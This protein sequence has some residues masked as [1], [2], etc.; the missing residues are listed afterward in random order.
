MIVVVRMRVFFCPRPRDMLCLCVA[1]RA[2]ACCSTSSCSAFAQSWNSS[3]TLASSWR[4][5]WCEDKALKSARIADT[6][7]SRPR[8]CTFFLIQAAGEQTIGDHA[9]FAMLISDAEEYFSG[10]CSLLLGALFLD[11]GACEGR[12]LASQRTCV[13]RCVTSQGGPAMLVLRTIISCIRV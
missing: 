8:A 11:Q 7:A 2:P 5:P 3:L 6:N 10:P 1:A 9:L 12:G 13:M 4:S